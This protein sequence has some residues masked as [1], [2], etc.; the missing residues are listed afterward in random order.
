MKNDKDDNLGALK[1]ELN[2]KVES[3]MGPVP[4]NQ[5]TFNSK[6]PDRYK[7]KTSEQNPTTAPKIA[8]NSEVKQPV[9]DKIESNSSTVVDNNDSD[10]EVDKAVDDIAEKE[11]DELL[12]VEDEAVEKAFASDNKKENWL[13]RFWHN[14]IARRTFLLLLLVAI[15]TLGAIPTTRY[16]ILNSVGV[17]SSA[18]LRVV[19]SST[20][21]PLKNVNV[22]LGES[23]GITNEQ[24]VASL[25]K[26]KL[27]QQNLVIE[28]RA[29][30]KT[31]KKI[32]IGWGSN[33]LGESSIEPTGVQYNFNVKDFLSKKPIVKAE[34]YSGDASAFSDKDG[35]ATLTLDT[36]GDEPVVINIRAD[37]YREEKLK[38]NVSIDSSYRNVEMAPAQKQVFITKR[39]GKYD[40]YKIDADGKNEELVLSG[41][42][43][44]RGDITLAVH[45]TDSFAALV[46]TR[47][48]IRSSDKMLMSSLTMIEVDSNKTQPVDSSERIQVVGWIDD[49]LI[50]VKVNDAKKKNGVSTHT[51]ISYDY[52]NDIK[53]E[54]ASNLFFNDVSVVGDQI[55]YAPAAE[56][57]YN[58]DESAQKT[59]NKDS[60]GLFST[61]GAGGNKQTIISKEIWSISRTDFETLVLG[62]GQDWYEY[63]L[64]SAQ[65]NKMSGAPA[66]QINRIYVNN[67]TDKKSL[68]VDKRDGKGVLL[69]LDISSKEDRVLASLSGLSN[70]IR[71]L[72]ATTAVFRIQTDQE[73]ADYAISLSGGDAK[74]ISDV[75][76]TSGIDNW[77]YY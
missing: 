42:G 53:T 33:P 75:T 25:S 38:N 48:N 3:I 21:Q 63:K 8:N 71:W 76:A 77:Y 60:L 26:V 62:S 37:G 15:L 24:G 4:D 52:V 54:V 66:E 10:S 47:D 36:N 57:E 55:F 34:V 45:P 1:N 64:G 70:P 67:K 59:I 50:Y 56:Y 14:K 44:E 2:Q 68:W 29:Y 30:A 61:D 58:E 13:K 27:G 73:T 16:Y 6:E 51:L 23:S 18:S 9:N 46:S 7:P 22:T 69:D 40:V 5:N 20:Q 28:R 17:R 12:N 74:K 65:A 31:E 11:A 39:S 19:D 32:V 41:T 35:K 72:N 49:K 43:S